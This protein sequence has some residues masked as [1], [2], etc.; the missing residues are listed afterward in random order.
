MNKND[1]NSPIFAPSASLHQQQGQGFPVGMDH[2]PNEHK[3]IKN[4]KNLDEKYKYHQ[5]QRQGFPVGTDRSPGKQQVAGGSFADFLA[6]PYHKTCLIF[7][8]NFIK[9]PSSQ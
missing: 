6:I 9:H 3:K 2:C 8:I 1:F 7:T 5:Q 4:D